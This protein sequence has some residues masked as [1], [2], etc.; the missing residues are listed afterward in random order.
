MK[1]IQFNNITLETIDSWSYTFINE[2]HSI[3]HSKKIGE[4]YCLISLYAIDKNNGSIKKMANTTLKEY[5]KRDSFRLISSSNG[6]KKTVLNR[7]FTFF[8]TEKET[9]MNC[10]EFM[11]EDKDMCYVISG[12]IPNSPLLNKY[13]ELFNAMCSSVELLHPN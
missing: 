2:K 10:I 12:K 11:L 5:E 7:E 3:I 4:S 9:M 1:K 13:S 6:K 8:N